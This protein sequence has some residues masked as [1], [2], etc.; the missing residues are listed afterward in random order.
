[1]KKTG[2]VA[3]GKG[4]RKKVNKSSKEVENKLKKI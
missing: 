3:P 1:M 4:I 2:L